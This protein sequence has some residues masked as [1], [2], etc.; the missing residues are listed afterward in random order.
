MESGVRWCGVAFRHRCHV[1]LTAAHF[2]LMG[3]CVVICIVC[4]FLVPGLYRWRV[5]RG[6]DDAENALG[7][8][9]H[10]QALFTTNVHQR[11]FHLMKT[12]SNARRLK[13]QDKNRKEWR[14]AKM[15][16]L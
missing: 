6:T 5:C 16:S 9:R 8:S 14:Y 10:V 11:S 12:G 2:F 4:T 15:S 13:R 3:L 7:G 1:Y